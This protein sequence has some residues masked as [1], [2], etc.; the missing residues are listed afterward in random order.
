MQSYKLQ[1]VATDTIQS[2][3]E[4]IYEKILTYNIDTE[5]IFSSSEADT[6]IKEIESVVRS[7]NINKETILD[8]ELPI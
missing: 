2:K 5:H 7:H 3:E 6:F 4:Q 8:K 1:I